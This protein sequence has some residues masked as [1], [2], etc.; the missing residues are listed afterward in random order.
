[1]LLSTEQM[2]PVSGLDVPRD[3]Y[4]A[5]TDPAP[6]AG[7][8]YPTRPAAWGELYRL[9]VRHLICL[10]ADSLPYDPTPLHALL[11]TR[12]EDLVGGH[13]PEDPA[14]ERRKIV[15][16]A[17]VAARAAARA[18]GVV[19]HCAGGTGRTGTVLGCALRML[20]YPSVD[21]VRWLDRVNRDRGKDG[22]PEAAWQASVV[23]GVGVD[24]AAIRPPRGE[25]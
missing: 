14:A 23:E 12:L 22:W 21:V 4:F 19:I 8:A 11:A 20:G 9:G 13:P 24:T 25:T 16:A 1:M 15:H 2:P 17:A 10:T 7:M 5:L 18:E 6:L 3:V